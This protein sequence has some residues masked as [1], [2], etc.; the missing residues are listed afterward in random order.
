MLNIK[1]ATIWGIVLTLI[2]FLIATILVL[3]SPD[4]HIIIGIIIFPLV[5]FLYSKFVYFRKEDIQAPIKEGFLVGL[6]WLIIA[7][8][9]DIIVLVYILGV[10]WEVFSSW[11]LI[12]HYVELVVFTVLG[13]LTEKK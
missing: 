2:T 12:V 9:Y 10:G 11:V 5:I 13:P 6:Y 7:I 1:R 4:L 8:I 3:I